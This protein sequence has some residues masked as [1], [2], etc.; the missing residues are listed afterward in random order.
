[1]S[2]H[3][4]KRFR[5]SIKALLAVIALAAVGLAIGVKAER[6]ARDS[7]NSKATMYQAK[8][9]ALA[10][11]RHEATFKAFPEATIS[12][13][14]ERPAKSWRASIAVY[15][16]EVNFNSDYE[17]SL[18]WNS[19]ANDSLC[20]RRNLAHDYFAREGTHNQNQFCTNFIVVTGPGTLFPA[21][22]KTSLSDVSDD[23]ATT[24][25]FVEIDHS[26]ILWYEPRDLHFDQMSF[27]INDPYRSKPCI[28]NRHF[29]GAIVGMADFSVR[30]LSQDTP[31]ETLKAMLTIA[32]GEKVSPP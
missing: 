14:Q 20:R 8:Q 6:R 17:S 3:P 28:G 24:I 11:L 12:D 21:D 2:N 16:C 5:F 15:L 29:Q 9:I 19:P 10:L 1:M 18:P 23:P 32:G 25:M 4:T 31:P 7:A 26:D 22:R 30:F 27:Q 13:A